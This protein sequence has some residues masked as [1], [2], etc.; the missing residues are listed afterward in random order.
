M[1]KSFVKLIFESDYD[2][3]SKPGGMEKHRNG[4]PGTT[5][6]EKNP[7]WK[8]WISTTSKGANPGQSSKPN[9]MIKA[10]KAPKG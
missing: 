3:T 1:E 8:T 10:E 5:R 4:F 6:T 7:K 2:P 9:L